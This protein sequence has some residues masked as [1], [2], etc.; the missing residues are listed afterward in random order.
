MTVVLRLLD[1]YVSDTVNPAT[2]EPI[3]FDKRYLL[4]EVAPRRD[5]WVQIKTIFE[6]N[7]PPVWIPERLVEV[8]QPGFYRA[9]AGIELE[10]SG[11]EITKV[12]DYVKVI[13]V[14]PLRFSSRWLAVKLDGSGDDVLCEPAWLEVADVPVDPPGSTPRPSSPTPLKRILGSIN[15]VRRHTFSA[16][17]TSS[18][19]DSSS[20]EHP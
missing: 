10:H 2:N 1:D 17:D 19:D 13:N 20:E 9:R 14:N 7:V 6:N 3:K 4:I 12:S 15:R 11:K 18:E 16:S 8:A 5:G